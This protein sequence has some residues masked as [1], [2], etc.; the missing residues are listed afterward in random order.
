MDRKTGTFIK[1]AYKELTGSLKPLFDQL[2]FSTKGLKHQAQRETVFYSIMKAALS[3]PDNLVFWTSNKQKYNSEK[4]PVALNCFQTVVDSM[5]AMEW[6]SLDETQI[7]K[8]GLS[9]RWFVAQHLTDYILD[10]GRQLEWYD[11]KPKRERKAKNQ[12]V[13]VRRSR[14]RKGLRLRGFKLPI[15]NFDQEDLSKHQDQMLE[16]NNL[17]L[18]HKFEGLC[19]KD[20]EPF[21]FSGLYRVFNQTLTRGGRMYGGV[22]QMPK[23]LRKLNLRIDGS[24]VAVVDIKSSHTNILYSLYLKE[25]STR[26]AIRK[27]AKP[28]NELHQPSSSP[29]GTRGLTPDHSNEGKDFYQITSDKLNGLLTRKEVKEI[30]NQAIGK[31]ELSQSRW[32]R[33]YRVKGVSWKEDVFPTF[34]TVMPFLANLKPVQLD[35][36]IL[37]YIEA[38]ILFDAMY[39]LYKHRGIAVL[40]IHDAFVCRVEDLEIVTSVLKS[41]FEFKTGLRPICSVE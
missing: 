10:G 26:S 6:L 11:L 19:F 40:P 13:E 36:L 4:Y 16:L 9:R 17:M 39:G 38:D 37:Q 18:Q 1:P 7:A 27:K 20:G 41:T 28:I 3:D 5:K 15:F 32:P 14:L 21:E 12:L 2:S 30:V 31:G 8:D 22:E 23:V 34:M 33:G 29:D 35:G 25:C 24:R